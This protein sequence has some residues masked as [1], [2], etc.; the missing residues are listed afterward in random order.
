MAEE[1]LLPKDGAETSSYRLAVYSALGT[2]ALGVV[3]I[4]GASFSPYQEMR[5]V[6]AG[7]LK[8]YVIPAVIGNAAIFMQYI[9]GR[10]KI[11][12]AKTEAY[13]VINAPPSGQSVTVEQSTKE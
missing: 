13:S 5:E 2:V 10:S 1:T 3:L 8:L 11:S 12:V 6:L 4:L 7:L 9:N